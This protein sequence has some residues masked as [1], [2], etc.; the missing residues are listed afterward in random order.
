MAPR[1]NHFLLCQEATAAE[2]GFVNIQGF[3]SGNEILAPGPGHF[4]RLVLLLCFNGMKGISRTRPTVE[5]KVG[6]TQ[7]FRGAL[8]WVDRTPDPDWYWQRIGLEMFPVP[9]E[10]LYTIAVSLEFQPG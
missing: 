7:I 4:E 8:S 3:L 1:L 6:P 2:G 9:R 10:G 5:I